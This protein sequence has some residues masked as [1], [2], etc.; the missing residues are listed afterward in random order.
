MTRAERS[1]SIAF[2]GCLLETDDTTPTTIALSTWLV[3]DHVTKATRMVTILT[4][5]HVL[6]WCMIIWKS[7]GFLPPMA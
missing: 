3:I 6:N 1:G 4:R 7:Y 2:P 5:L